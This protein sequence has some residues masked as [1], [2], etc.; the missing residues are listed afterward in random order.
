MSATHVQVVKWSFPAFALLIG[1]LWYKRRKVDRADPGGIDKSDHSDKSLANRK[2][3]VTSSKSDLNFYDSGIHIDESFSLNSSNQ[4]IEE[5]ICSPRKH[6]ESLDI[7]QRKGSSQCTS[8][9]STTPPKDS[10]VW[11]SYMDTSSNKMDIQLG[12]NPKINNFDMIARSRSASSLENAT[13]SS[14]KVLKIFENVVEEE[15]QKLSCEDNSEE[16]INT[17]EEN[18]INNECDYLLSKEPPAATPPKDGVKTPVLVLSERDSANHSPVSGVLEGSVT[19]EARSEG[20]TDSGKGGSIKGHTKDSAGPVLYEFCIP[21]HLVGRLIGRHGNFLHS[22][23]LKAEVHIVVKNYPIMKDQKICAIEGSS[24]GVNIALDMIRQKFPEEKYPN[25]TLEQILSSKTSEENQW[26]TELMQLS[27]VEGVNNDV[28]VCHVVKPNRVFVQL[29]T[30]PTYPSL[31]ILERNMT[32]LYDTIETPPVPDELSKGMILVAKWY[33]NWVRVCVEQPDP[34]GEQHLVRLVD[35]GGYWQFSNAEMK[36][37]R[38][39]YLTLPF[40]AIEIFLANVQ[41]KNGEWT[42]EALNVVAHMCYGIVGQAQIEGYINTSTYVNL[43]LNI[44]NHGVIS[45]ADELIARGLAESV[46]LE[47][48]VPED[49]ITLS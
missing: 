48:I 12:S 24:E 11:Y 6:S 3:E 10:Q 31:R 29:P 32:Q 13:D 28:V 23:R 25:V 4:P 22:I 18:D 21:Q 37:I 39:D 20:S 44:H 36:K 41:P 2:K 14:N 17:H 46:P 1:L 26:I 30:H 42:Q 38:S 33:N 5:I 45:L 40:Q 34:H 7:P 47:S 9:H 43:F 27:L 49:S 19:D 8:A 16:L 35:H 15:E